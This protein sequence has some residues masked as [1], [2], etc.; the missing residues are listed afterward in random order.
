MADPQQAVSQADWDA[1]KPITQ[2]DW[3]SAKP[4]SASGKTTSPSAWD[5]ALTAAKQFASNF[6]PVTMGESLFEAAREHPALASIAGPLGPAIYEGA[7]QQYQKARDAYQQGRYSEAAGHTLAMAL[8][9]VGPMAANAGEEIGTGDPETMAKGVGDT[10]AIFAAPK[11]AEVATDAAKMA[12]P[13]VDNALRTRASSAATVKA[14]AQSAKAFGDITKAVPPSATTPY[15][16]ADLRRAT[17]YLAAEHAQSPV[18]TVDGLREAADSSITQIEQHVAN[19][20]DANPHRTITTDPLAVVRQKLGAGE[21]SDDLALGLKE[22]DGLGLSNDMLLKDADRVRLRLNAENQAILARNQ[23]DVGTALK[24]DPAFAARYY[25]SQALRDGI[26]DALDQQGIP[27]VRQLRQDEGSLIK[28]R[29]AA[30]AKAFG[31]E[32]TVSGTGSNSMPARVTRAVAPAVGGAMGSMVAG[33]FGAAGGATIANDVA[34]AV[35]PKNLTRDALIE[36]GFSRIGQ[37]APPSYPTVPAPSPVRGQLSA[38]ATPLA[39]PA[40]T[41]VPNVMPPVVGGTSQ[42]TVFSRLQLPAGTANGELTRTRLGPAPDTS[43]GQVFD[44]RLIVVRDPKTG[45]FKRVYT[46]EPKSGGS[47]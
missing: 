8:P 6:N 45:R 17:P 9:L 2:S 47:R 23:Y 4:L 28:I 38:P 22:L 1:A 36:R 24:A 42:P 44:A 11:V 26:Y 21:R 19:Y 25:A 29:D 14:A 3:D 40:R 5:L 10:A 33:P 31:G 13:A 37:M 12:L 7:K 46:T 32:K 41:T 34:R 15:E 16:A 39:A 43:G 27:G 20:I 30:Q 18:T 35:L